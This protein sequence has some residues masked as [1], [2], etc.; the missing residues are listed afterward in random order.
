MCESTESLG[1]TLVAILTM[2]NGRDL[3]GT[4]L[5]TVTS[6]IR[7]C[8]AGIEDLK[9]KLDKVKM[10]APDGTWKPLAANAK[11]KATYPFRESTLVKL[12]EICSE[13]KDNLA[14]AIDA[15]QIDMATI[16]LQ[17]LESVDLTTVAIQKDLKRLEGEMSA[18]TIGIYSLVTS[19][20]G[21]LLA[22][23]YAWLTPLS[24]VFNNKQ[25][26]TLA[27]KTRQDAGAR[28][29]LETEEF[30]IWKKGPG[31][32]LWCIG[33]PGTGKTVNMSFIIEALLQKRK[34]DA[35]GVAF[36]YFSYKDG[37]I[38]TP[39]NLM[40]S[41]LQQLVSQKPEYLQDLK[42]LYHKHVRENT[43]PD[44]GEISDLLLPI[45]WS[46][47]QVFI[48][49]DALDECSDADDVRFI[50]LTEL[51]KYK[52]RVCLLI[53]SR[54]LP[55]LEEGL[56]NAVRV[57]AKASESD[58][59]NYLEQRLASVKIMQKH[60]VDEPSLKS[61]IVSTIIL[62]IK[63]MFLMARLYLDTLTTK[64]TRRKIKSALDNLPEGLDSIYDELMERIKLQNPRDHADLAIRV[65]GWIF[66][67]V[68]PL[69]V[70][71]VQHALAIE[72]GDRD[73]DCDGIPDTDLLVSVCVGMV[74]INRESDTVTLVHYTAQE[75]F[76]RG[77][78][79]VLEHANRDI[80]R[81]C[82]TYLHFDNINLDTDHSPNNIARMLGEHTLLGYAAQHWGDHARQ[83][84]D[85]QITQCTVRLLGSQ[86][87][88]HLLVHAKD[89]ADNHSKGTYFKPRRNVDGLSLASSFGLASAVSALLQ[90]G[91][92]IDSADSNGQRALYR[93]VGGGHMKTIQI[94]LDKGAEINAKDSIGWT[95]LHLACSDGQT[96]LVRLLLQ[97]DA[98][99]NIV[100]GYKTTPLYRAA[101]SGSEAVADLLLSKQA[102]LSIKSS[103][104]Q[105]ALHRAA[106]RGHAGI[107][108]LLLRY[109]ADVA[110]KDHYGY[111][112][113]YRAA[114]QGNDEVVRILRAHMDRI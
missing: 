67:A 106:D 39:V 32:I 96:E 3:S 56:E 46:F 18:T 6:S 37:E 107:V 16:A 11:K 81:T 20:E 60:F 28:A 5:E 2:T 100:D 97:K 17:R 91:S 41:L 52:S 24:T 108:Q 109:G 15:L 42:S 21:E 36:I 72:E 74:V 4:V 26:D 48:I 64:T 111:T 43:R 92:D 70:Q 34:V 13:L 7:S 65:L 53:A 114:D 77:K 31:T 63:G 58:I 73:L 103:Y 85:D 62:K 33:M 22:K 86:T 101:E 29:L 57:Y 104:L 49:I 12:R 76:Q 40:A 84:D 94:L 93:A 80:A 10:L 55:K 89:Y 25:R 82:L 44:V 1:K 27:T 23:I 30:K 35:S 69:T 51:K 90:S 102:D 59:K 71:E 112:A 88:V 9:K 110:A 19:Q 66:F 47:P 83:A 78:K 105:T 79:H 50:L 87:R 98:D 68:R 61:T 14:L 99:I 38:Q 45:I 54:P 113:F 95:A 8:Q 75:Y